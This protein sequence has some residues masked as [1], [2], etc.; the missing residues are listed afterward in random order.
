V[1]ALL[2]L[3]LLPGL[4][5]ASVGKISILEGTAS[6]KDANGQEHAL[7]VGAEVELKDTLQVGA[8]S[9][10]K[11]LLTDESVLM[12]GANSQLYLD[13]ATFE[14]QERKG[15]SAKL[16]FGRV[17][18]KVRQMAAGSEAKF[19]V[20]TERAVAGVRGTIFRVDYGSTAKAVTPMVK[21]SMVV[22]VVQGRVV[23]QV[24]KP[25]TKQVPVAQSAPPV[26][27]GK[28]TA[29]VQ[30]QGPQQVTM[31]EWMELFADLQAGQQT[32]VGDRELGATK[33]R[34]VKPLDKKAMQDDFGRFVDQNQ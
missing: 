31:S 24:P 28:K 12:L 27:G 2:P 5:L 10:L 6:R 23:V 30:V 15:F 17:W 33:D 25:V 20:T 9:N 14:G 8:A 29:R 22:R 18:A 11:L 7:K 34:V 21:P 19:E 26:A 1:K 32:E 3:L 16:V 4:A 13:E